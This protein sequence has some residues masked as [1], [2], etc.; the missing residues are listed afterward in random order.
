MKRLPALLVF[1][2]LGL[3]IAGLWWV[4]RKPQGAAFVSGTLEGRE[5]PLSVP[6]ALPVLRVAVAEGQR[7]A[8]GDTLIVLDTLA[9]HAQRAALQAQKTALDHQ[10]Q[11]ARILLRQYRRDLQRL[12]TLA[13]QAVPSQK[14]EELEARLRAQEEQIAALQ[15]Q[16]AALQHQMAALEHQKSLAVLTAPCAGWVD[17]VPVR[18]GE[19]P[20]PGQT[21]VTVVRTD[22]LEFHTAIPQNLLSRLRV[23]DTLKIRLDV[24]GTVTGILSW[25][26]REPEFTPRSLQTS[27]ERA[28]LVYPARVLVPNPRGTLRPGMTGLLLLPRP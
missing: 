4:S 26:S 7:V 13:H 14:V 16:Q 28:R 19:T 15:G 17:Q 1:L 18:E 20:L 25:L 23:G 24:N 21:L 6:L 22:T 2:A 10:I 9:L 8:A 27:E 11:A 12:Q 5:Y 3:G